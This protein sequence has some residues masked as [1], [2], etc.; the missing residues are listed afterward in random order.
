VNYLPTRISLLS[1]TAPPPLNPKLQTCL[2]ERVMREYERDGAMIRKAIAT[3]RGLDLS[4]VP[5]PLRRATEEALDKAEKTFPLVE[6]IK[7]DEAAVQ[8]K[9]D[10]YRPLHVEVRS[11]QQQAHGVGEDIKV[12]QRRLDQLGYAANADPDRKQALQTRIDALEAERKAILA[13]VPAQWEAEH[14]AFQAL[15]K[16]ELN[17][18]RAYR[19]NVDEA[20]APIAELVATIAAADK[21]AALEGDLAKLRES[22]ASAPPAEN[23]DRIAELVKALT[24]IKGTNAIRSALSDA[25]RALRAQTP[26]QQEASESMAKA[27]QLV[28]DE[29]AWHQRAKTALLPGLETYEATIRDTIGVRQQSKLTR[30]QALEMASSTSAHRDIS[31]HF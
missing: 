17:A 10:A 22:V 28:A 3:A 21:L 31:V 20:Y 25:R 24:D 16:T 9:T 23:V 26:N 30:D 2:E 4:P 5:Q 19:R 6:Q 1:E 15:Q 14:K 12:L 7:K 27:E 11:L 8:A 18:R 13:K 29:V